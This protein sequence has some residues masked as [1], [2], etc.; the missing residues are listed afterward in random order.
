M[1]TEDNAWQELRR[2]AASR[3]APGFADRVLRAARAGAA[4][5]PSYQSQFAL[6]A[7]TAALCLVAVALYHH[8]STADENARNLARW[9]EIVS[10]ADEL[11]Q[12][13]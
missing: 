10:Q 1:K 3:L 12:T 13:L 2:H 6:C 5:A 7:A 9:Q 11:D 4:S 8:H